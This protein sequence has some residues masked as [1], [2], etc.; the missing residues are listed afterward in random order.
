MVPPAGP[1]KF[2]GRPVP[3]KGESILMK[4]SLPTTTLIRPLS[5]RTFNWLLLLSPGIAAWLYLS[6]RS[7]GQRPWLK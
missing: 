1:C 3:N 4:T 5:R 2:F 6:A 7:R